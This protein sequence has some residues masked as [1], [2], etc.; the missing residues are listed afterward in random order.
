MAP[1]TDTQAAPR[2]RLGREWKVLIVV[3]LAVFMSSL[4]LF[5]VN[6]AL[7]AIRRGFPGAG[8]G[9]LSWVLNAY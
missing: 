4:D 7:P 5:I 2:R 9:G 1:R 8:V 3:S 6:I